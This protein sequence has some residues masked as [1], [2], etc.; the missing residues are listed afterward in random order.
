MLQAL[1]DVSFEVARGEFFG[2]VGRNGSGKS[3]LLKCIA[4]IYGIDAGAIAMRRPAVA[5]HRARAW[6]STRTSP[7]ATT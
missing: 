4:G 5:V 1:D 6:A 2:I 7:R 3:T